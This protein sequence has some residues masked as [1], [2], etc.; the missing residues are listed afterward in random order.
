MTPKFIP[1]PSYFNASFE[2]HTLTLEFFR[3]ENSETR[4]EGWQWRIAGPLLNVRGTEKQ[5]ERAVQI[6]EALCGALDALK[7]VS[8]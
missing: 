8:T 2:G 1:R 3:A 5:Q 6:L 7:A 4:T